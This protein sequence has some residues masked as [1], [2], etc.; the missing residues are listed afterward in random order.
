MDAD[1]HAFDGWAQRKR[2]RRVWLLAGALIVGSWGVFIASI[3]LWPRRETVVQAH[4]A[5]AAF[6]AVADAQV[7][8]LAKSIFTDE[9]VEILRADHRDGTRL[10]LL[11]NQP[12][13]EA[14]LIRMVQPFIDFE[15]SSYKVWFKA[16]VYYDRRAWYLDEEFEPKAASGSS[17]KMFSLYLNSGPLDGWKAVLEGP[18]P[19]RSTVGGCVDAFERQANKSDYVRFL[20][21][22]REKRE[23]RLEYKPP[24]R[25]TCMP[26]LIL[27]TIEFFVPGSGWGAFGSIPGLDSLAVQVIDKELGRVATVEI[28]WLG[29]AASRRKY[30]EPGRYDRRNELMDQRW[31]DEADFESGLISESEFNNR[32]QQR[33]EELHAWYS[34]VWSAA[35]HLRGIRVTFDHKLPT[36]FTR[37]FAGY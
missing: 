24:P 32:T 23:C 21:Y 30:W 3:R 18:V 16:F 8:K 5:P 20:G 37:E 14:D 34:E 31:T 10:A 12:L 13:S 15:K 36:G 25:V 4:Q 7:R 27:W 9:S 22:D 19:E 11:L 6:G 2:R 17:F 28:S 29:Y 1:Q 35:A 26:A 33:R